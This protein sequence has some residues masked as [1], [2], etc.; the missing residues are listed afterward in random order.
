MFMIYFA[1]DFFMSE[2]Y[3][4]QRSG[5][6]LQH[7]GVKGM[8]WGVRKAIEK[9]GA[10]GER[11]LEKQYA[12]A[13]KKLAK[14]TENANIKRQNELANKYDKAAKVAGKVGIAGAGVLAGL[15][16]AKNVNHL[17]YLKN[18]EKASKFR[19]KYSA[20]DYGSSKYD[21]KDLS[22][23]YRR[24][25]D[26]AFSRYISANDALD[27]RYGGTRSLIGT[28]ARVAAAGGLGVAAGMKLASKVAKNRTTTKGH[29]KAVAKRDAWKKNMQEV[30]K[31]TK[32]EKLPN[33]N[34]KKRR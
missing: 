34:K 11:K 15:H 32:Y 28:T 7:Y 27:P 25:E 24:K 10:K 2:Y 30:F 1:G 31:G 6:S 26:E 17:L 22:D 4:V 23:A 33:Q 9:G 19:D 3:A 18:K 14:L 13:A 21:Y 8:K 5:A 16:G 12:K 29:A 20:A